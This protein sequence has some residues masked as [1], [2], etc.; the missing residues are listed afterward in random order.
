MIIPDTYLADVNEVL[1]GPYITPIGAYNVGLVSMIVYQSIGD[2][3]PAFVLRAAADCTTLE[4]AAR[5][6]EAWLEQRLTGAELPGA[7]R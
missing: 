6:A 2:F 1:H 7:S 5:I 4:Q 3:P